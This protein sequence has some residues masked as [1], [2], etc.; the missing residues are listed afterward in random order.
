MP[1]QQAKSTCVHAE[2]IARHLT[3]AADDVIVRARVETVE[4]PERAPILVLKLYPGNVV[5]LEDKRGT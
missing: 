4:R 5:A 2:A 1:K 3:Y